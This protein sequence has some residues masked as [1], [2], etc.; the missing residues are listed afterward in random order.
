MSNV[1]L[2]EGEVSTDE[3]LNRAYLERIN[4]FDQAEVEADVAAWKAENM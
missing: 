4:S 3:I 1:G 2:I